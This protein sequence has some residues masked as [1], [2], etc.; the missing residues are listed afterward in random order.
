LVGRPSGGSAISACVAS[1]GLPFLHCL[2]AGGAL[3][4]VALVLPFMPTCLLLP[5]LPE[6]N[7][8]CY[9]S[10]AARSVALR[11]YRAACRLQEPGFFFPVPFC[12]SYAAWPVLWVPAM[13]G[14]LH[15]LCRCSTLLPTLGGFLLIPCLL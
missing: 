13:C 11:C 4:V 7:D 12:C 9:S 10:P 5:V 15:Y 6:P 8:T 2:M 14:Q 1:G 3:L